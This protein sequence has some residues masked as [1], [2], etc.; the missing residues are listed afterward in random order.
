MAN[1]VFS[2]PFNLRARYGAP[3]SLSWDQR[4]LDYIAKIESARNYKVS[5]ASLTVLVLVVP[6]VI[7]V[8]LTIPVVL[9]DRRLL[10]E[11]VVF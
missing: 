4:N 8:I 1:I 5:S 7:P 3:N 6:A 10:A 9:G 11:P 2:D